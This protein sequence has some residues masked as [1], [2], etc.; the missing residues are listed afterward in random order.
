MNKTDLNKMDWNAIQEQH[1]NGIYWT[2]LH[3]TIGVSKTVLERALKEGYVSKKIHE[4]NVSDVAKLRISEGRKKFLKENPD[5]HPWKNNDK[6]KSVPCELLKTKLI[7]NDV[8]FIEEYQPSNERFYSID[9]A[10]PNKKIGIEINGNQHYN[11]N[12]TLGEYYVNRNKY[13]NSI[14]WEIIDIHFSLVYSNSLLEKFI[15]LIKENTLTVEEFGNYTKEYY[16]RKNKKKNE[17]ILR[18]NEKSNTIIQKIELIKNAL[19]LSEI[20][21]SKF[22]WVEKASV[23]IKN[24]PQKVNGWMK[25]NM[26]EF[27]AEKCFKKRVNVINLCCECGI[28]ISY[29]AKRC[30]ACN[31]INNRKVRPTIDQINKDMSILGITKTARKYSVARTTIARWLI[32]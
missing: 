19:L 2:N 32:E 15:A 22:G 27:Y 28:K 20:D 8:L 24:N 10:F 14:G 5:K 25:K 13:L 26:P 11:R 3:K 18:K 9:I 30:D 31:R 1:D 6:F 4:R 23:I 7:E 16:E 29:E 17:L 12:G 21:F